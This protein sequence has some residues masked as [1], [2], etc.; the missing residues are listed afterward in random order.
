[1]RFYLYFSPLAL[2]LL[3]STLSCSYSSLLH[4]FLHSISPLPSSFSILL[5]S[6]LPSTIQHLC[7]SLPTTVLSPHCTT[8]GIIPSA[9]DRAPFIEMAASTQFNQPTPLQ[10]W[11]QRYAH[12][13]PLP[14]D[15]CGRQQDDCQPRRFG[16]GSSVVVGHSPASCK[17]PIFRLSISCFL[18]LPETNG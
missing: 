5:L 14:T 8:P 18:A 7:F 15:P 6:S 12:D 2:I 3:L 11:S 13:S 16:H 10:L 17:E 4:S 9:T 1:M